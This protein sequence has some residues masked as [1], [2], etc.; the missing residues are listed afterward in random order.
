MDTASGE[1]GDEATNPVSHMPT[2][3]PQFSHAQWTHMPG[4]TM[5]KDADM[6]GVGGGGV[7]GAR[8]RMAG[9]G[10]WHIQLSLPVGTATSTV[11]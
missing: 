11:C 10:F 1:G 3:K 8:A 7:G 9:H 4:L 6:A 2:G 5:G